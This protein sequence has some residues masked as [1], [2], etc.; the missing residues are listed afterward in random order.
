MFKTIRESVYIPSPPPSL[1]GNAHVETMQFKGASISLNWIL[2]LIL[3]SD[4]ILSS[5]T[6][7]GGGRGWVLTD[8]LERVV[9]FRHTF[10]SL[11]GVPNDHH[12]RA[13]ESVH[14]MSHFFAINR[15]TNW[16]SWHSL[17]K[18][19]SFV[20]LFRHLRGPNWPFGCLDSEVISPLYFHVLRILYRI[21]HLFVSHQLEVYCNSSVLLTV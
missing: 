12:N 17:R 9:I 18:C 13:W 15:V 14:F 20:T 3:E 10:S 7:S 1:M 19:S 21:F 11:T 6:G 4:K 16:P 8:L 2:T 5:A